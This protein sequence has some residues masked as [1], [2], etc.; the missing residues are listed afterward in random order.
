MKSPDSPAALVNDRE[1]AATRV[2][3]APRQLVFKVWTDPNHLASWW[4]PR[5]FRTTT[6]HMEAKPGGMW[7][8]VMHG[9]DGVDYHNKITFLEVVEGER[10]V[11]QHGGDKD[12]E[13]VNF[14]VTVTFSEYGGKTLVNMRM[15][16]PSAGA[17]DHVVNTYG[18]IP[19]LDQ[20]L[21]RLTEHLASRDDA[22][23]P[24]VISRVFDAPRELVWNA[25]TQRDHLLN[26]FGPKGF[27][28]RVATL[29]FRPGGVFHYCMRSPA[30]QDMWG[31]FVYREIIAPQRIVLVNSFSDE[32]GNITRHPLSATWPREM[33]TT[34]TFGEYQGKTTVTLE[35]APLNATEA[36]QKTFDEGRQGMTMGWTG[37][38]DQLAKYLAQRA[39]G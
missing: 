25:W 16:F 14:H 12:C 3:D 20:T 31:K 17:R 37:T 8:Y 18:A 19:G 35:W 36:E 22:N 1:I 39:A 11:Y 23:R 30:G 32:Q 4:G 6:F 10:L 2:F 15:V 7:R 27:T 9:P 34:T 38:F 5:G 13:P 21:G 26:W 24:F 28:M 29:D 33:L